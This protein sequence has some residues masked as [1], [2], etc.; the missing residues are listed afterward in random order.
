MESLRL[1]P[2]FRIFP[3]RCVTSFAYFVWLLFEVFFFQ[4]RISFI[5]QYV[6][7]KCMYTLGN[8]KFPNWKANYSNDNQYVYHKNINFS[9]CYFIFQLKQ[10]RHQRNKNSVKLLLIVLWIVMMDIDSN[11]QLMENVLYVNAISVRLSSGCNQSSAKSY[12]LFFCFNKYVFR[13]F[14]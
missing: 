1:F 6:Y 10:Q 13:S 3:W 8:N 12:F 4:F 2:S 11:L 9:R 7:H 5:T 14:S